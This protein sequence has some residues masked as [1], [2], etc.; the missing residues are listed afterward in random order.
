MLLSGGED[1]ILNI[2][3]TGG[4]RIGAASAKISLGDASVASSNDDHL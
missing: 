4:I 3:E 2:G 1:F